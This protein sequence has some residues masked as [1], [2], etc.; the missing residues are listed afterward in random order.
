[1]QNVKNVF[2]IF[3]RVCDF[4]SLMPNCRPRYHLAGVADDALYNRVLFAFII[5]TQYTI[6]IVITSVLT[7]HMIRSLEKNPHVFLFAKTKRLVSIGYENMSFPFL[8][9]RFLQIEYH[10]LLFVV[11]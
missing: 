6:F 4:T 5:H 2:A 1:M 9:G 11:V 10:F 8:A 7:G 3:G